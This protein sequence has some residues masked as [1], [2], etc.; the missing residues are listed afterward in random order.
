MNR[1]SIYIC[2]SVTKLCLSHCD[3]SSI[4][5]SLLKFMSTESV[6]PSN[7]LILCCPLLF[8]PSICPSIRVFPSELA[9]WIRWPKYWSFSFSISPSNE[10]SE[11]ISFR[12]DWFDFLA[13]QATLKIFSNTTLGKHQ[14]FS[15]QPFLKSLGV[16]N[17][18]IP[19]PVFLP[20][21]FHGQKGLVCYSPRGCKELDMTEHTNTHTSLFYKFF[22]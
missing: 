8:L 16:G 11:L 4:F 2:C 9:I 1:L 3:P 14:L 13:V 19:T 10:N 18:E 12:I 6:M 15:A 5:W 17:G 22:A 20:A 21:E 7:H